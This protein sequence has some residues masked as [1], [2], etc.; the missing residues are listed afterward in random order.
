M[1]RIRSF[2]PTTY[3]RGRIVELSDTTWRVYVHAQS[4]ADD[5]GNCRADV[6]WLSAQ[7]FQESSRRADVERALRELAAVNLIATYDGPDDEA[8][9]HFNGW[10]TRLQR[11]HNAGQP[12]IPYPPWA[13]AGRPETCDTHGISTPRNGK[14]PL[15]S[16]SLGGS[17]KS[18]ESLGEIPASRARA[19]LGIRDQ[20]S[21][22][23]EMDQGGGAGGGTYAS[24]PESQPQT[25]TPA[26][27]SSGGS[28]RS[29]SS[30]PSKGDQPSKESRSEPSP[31]TAPPATDRNP[32]VASF[33]LASP[34]PVAPPQK[35]KKGARKPK[36]PV[37]ASPLE[38]ATLTPYE[39]EV[40]DAI[41]ADPC[42]KPIVKDPAEAARRFVRIAP[43]VNLP[44]EIAK[45]GTWLF[46][47][48][49]RMQ[50]GVQF[51]LNWIGKVQEQ[52]GTPGWSP[53][54]NEPPKPKRPPP[55]TPPG[56]D[57]TPFMRPRQVRSL[58]ELG[59]EVGRPPG[60]SRESQAEQDAELAKIVEK[61][62]HLRHAAGDA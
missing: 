1:A 7:I 21:G 42:L 54:S 50:S 15:S 56:P 36:A 3:E 46:G 41:V 4:L 24:N 39:R 45:A 55:P 62:G 60:W 18:S 23:R 19:P 26:A 49:S 20:G 38:L 25:T 58:E 51:L 9:L 31:A 6:R 57:L 5:H 37:T 34:E 10:T 14:T 47:K 33:A 16:E 22:I 32:G 28:R 30:P 44:V 40:H 35:P 61:Y 27:A 59:D 29:P 53:P 11:I 13:V 17:R 8:Y 48:G 43:T 52:G 12:Q 2:V